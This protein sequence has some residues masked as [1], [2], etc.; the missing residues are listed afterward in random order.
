MSLEYYDLF[1]RPTVK[2]EAEFISRQCGEG[3][4]ILEF[5]AG[6]GLITQE[7]RHRGHSVTALEPDRDMR[8]ICADKK[9]AVAEGSFLRVP[10]A[11]Q[12]PYDAVVAFYHVFGIATQSI[13]DV[14]K[15]LKAVHRLL[16]PG[17]RFVF[18]VINSLCCTKE[19]LWRMRTETKKDENRVIERRSERGWFAHDSLLCANHRYTVFQDGE[20]I[21]E[22]MR[23]HHQRTF[24]PTEIEIAL[25]TCGFKRWMIARDPESISPGEGVLPTEKDWNIRVVAIRP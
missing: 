2:S 24:T 12:E 16:K 19:S 6:T 15:C 25:L 11:Y 7:L 5:G 4:S 21:H 20:Q 22:S 8:R 13:Y 9:I 14:E 17:G 1:R 23:W 10:E 3:A 18:D